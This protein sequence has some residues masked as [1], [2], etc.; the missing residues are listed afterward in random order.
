MLEKRGNE[1]PIAFEIRKIKIKLLLDIMTKITEAQLA[2]TLENAK[3][4]RAHEAG[5]ED[6]RK[7]VREIINTFIEDSN[8]GTAFHARRGSCADYQIDRTVS[9][10]KV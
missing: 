10:R 6:M 8:S 1:S 4:R 7:Q 2:L 3:A 9:N 5:F